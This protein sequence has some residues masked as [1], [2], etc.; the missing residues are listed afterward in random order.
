MR[1]YLFKCINFKK[2]FI[3]YKIM[4][5]IVKLENNKCKKQNKKK[6]DKQIIKKYTI[7]YYFSYFL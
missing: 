7:W 6:L 3:N 4:T 2:I 5:T 1:I